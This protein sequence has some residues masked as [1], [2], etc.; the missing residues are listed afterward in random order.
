EEEQGRSVARE[1]LK[2]RVVLGVG[3]T[4]DVKRAVIGLLG[5]VL[6]M[7]LEL[8]L[9]ETNSVVDGSAPAAVGRPNSRP[10]EV[11]DGEIGKIVARLLLTKMSLRV[12]VLVGLALSAEGCVRGTA[13]K[14]AERIIPTHVGVMVDADVFEAAGRSIVARSLVS[15]NEVKMGQAGELR[16]WGTDSFEQQPKLDKEQEEPYRQ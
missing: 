15:S 1:G 8:L 2:Q 12:S 16:G 6:L 13:K 3:A 7:E 4:Y 5:E 11:G 14:L 10:V 9:L